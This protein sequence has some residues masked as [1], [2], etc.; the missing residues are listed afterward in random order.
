MKAAKEKGFTFSL[1][2]KWRKEFFN[3][4]QNTGKTTDLGE[5]P[6]S[7]SLVE[8]ELNIEEN[9][10]SHSYFRGEKR[11]ERKSKSFLGW[12]PQKLQKICS[13]DDVYE[14]N[15]EQHKMLSEAR[16]VFFHPSLTRKADWK[17]RKSIHQLLFYF[18]FDS[19]LW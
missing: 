18:D 1:Q 6:F 10:A 2:K 14:V 11:G 8:R 4:I 7:E 12:D 3:W 13:I 5:N 16:K 9:G 19:H 15:T 17:V